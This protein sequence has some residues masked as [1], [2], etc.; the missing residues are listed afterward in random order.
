MGLGHFG[1]HVNQ[2]KGSE[3]AHMKFSTFG[4]SLR[5]N[6]LKHPNTLPMYAIAI[7]AIEIYSYQ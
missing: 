6:K 2:I 1:N 5:L 4:T 7:S 3:G